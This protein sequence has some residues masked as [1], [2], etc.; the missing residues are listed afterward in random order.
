MAP[1]YDEAQKRWKV[2]TEFKTFW[3]N[4]EDNAKQFVI[5]WL[6]GDK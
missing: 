2:V 1:I 3:F 5:L 6:A 4:L